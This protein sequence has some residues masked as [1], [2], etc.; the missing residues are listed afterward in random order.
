[1]FEWLINAFIISQVLVWIAIITDFLSFQYKERKKILILLTVSAL[2]VAVHYLLLDKTTA[3]FLVLLW[4]L[5]FITSIFTHNKKI[6]SLFLVLY[7][8]AF[9]INF[10]ELYDIIIFIWLF[11]ILISKF[12][13]DDKYL[14]IIMMIWTTFVILYNIIIFTPLW[15]VLESLFL[16]SNLIWYYRHY[17]KK[18]IIT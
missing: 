2:L 14:R 4:V 6:L 3:F 15:V 17:L 13:K 5:S 11:I 1:M 9:L 16:W 12:Q 7:L 8:I 18:K 10:K